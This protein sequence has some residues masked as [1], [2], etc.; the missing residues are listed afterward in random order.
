MVFKN[1]RKYFLTGIATILPLVITVWILRWLFTVVDNV[2][3]KPFIAFVKIY[4]EYPGIEW[5]ARVFLLVLFIFI[6]SF[7]G[8]LISFLFFRK[9]LAGLENLFLKFP[10]IGKIYKSIKQ[11]SSAIVGE[12]KNVFKEVVLV[13][14]PANGRFCIGFLTAEAEH[15]IN[16]ASSNDLVAIFIPTTP[17]PTSGMLVYYPKEA[18]KHLDISVEEGMRIVISAGTATV[19]SYD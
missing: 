5:L 1:L 3:L 18:V 14:Y 9:M 2:L 11:V 6:V 12:G 10:F 13:E 4:L 16:Q 7:L 8:F 19:A 15:I 17:N